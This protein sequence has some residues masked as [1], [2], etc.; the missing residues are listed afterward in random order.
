[1]SQNDTPP[2]ASLT[3]LV[4]M[5]GTQVMAAMGK[6][7]IPGQEK[8]EKRL[9]VAKHFID[10]LDVLEAKTKGNLDPSEAEMLTTTIHQLRLLYVQQTS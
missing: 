8:M 5:L 4:S 3:M 7:S 6:I 2:P 9:D 1:M 10:L